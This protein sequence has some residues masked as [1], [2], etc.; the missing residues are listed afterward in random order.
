MSF[1]CYIDRPE[2]GARRQTRKGAAGL[3][4]FPFGLLTADPRD[5]YSYANTGHGIVF[6][7]LSK[8]AFTPG[9]CAIP[10]P[11][12]PCLPVYL[13]INAT[14]VVWGAALT[15]HARTHTKQ[16]IQDTRLTDN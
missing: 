14:A 13:R 5:A 4:Y 6:R 1:L 12:A 2:P 11:N 10:S 3:L 16:E 8:Y 9:S 15:S 7:K